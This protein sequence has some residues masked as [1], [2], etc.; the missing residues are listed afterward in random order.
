MLKVPQTDIEYF[1][2][3]VEG[4]ETVHKLPL[5]EYLDGELVDELFSIEQI[6]KNAD[7]V[8]YSKHAMSAVKKLFDNYLPGLYKKL[9]MQQINFIVDNWSSRNKVSLGEFKASEKS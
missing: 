4:D 6:D 2:F 1:E 7:P 3:K 5:M 9:N 8:K